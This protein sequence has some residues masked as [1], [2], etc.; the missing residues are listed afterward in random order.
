MAS[1]MMLGDSTLKSLTPSVNTSLVHSL[2]T[3][4]ILELSVKSQL[5]GGEN[6]QFGQNTLCG[7]KVLLD[8]FLK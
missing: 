5:I 1:M 3:L 4:V 6:P 8:N 2:Q 7:M